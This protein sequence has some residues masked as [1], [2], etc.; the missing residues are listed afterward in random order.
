MESSTGGLGGIFSE[1]RS[2]GLSGALGMSELS[3]EGE[4]TRRVVR[5]LTRRMRDGGEVGREV[6]MTVCA[7]CD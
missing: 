1:E 5:I 2:T 6:V 4:T 3:A 7:I